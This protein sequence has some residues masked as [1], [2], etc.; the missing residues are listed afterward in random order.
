MI[1]NSLMNVI[2][3]LLSL[4]LSP[5]DIP[6]FPDGTEESVSQFFDLI[7]GSAESVIGLLVPTVVF[8]LLG[9]IVT[10]E[11]GIHLYHFVIWILK[12]IPMLGIE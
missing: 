9:I 8:V 6:G 12:K 5:L 4:V 1:I 7:F 11:V 3:N 2:Y 10:V